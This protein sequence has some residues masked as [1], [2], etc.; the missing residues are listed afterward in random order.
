MRTTPEFAFQNKELLIAKLDKLNV[1]YPEQLI[2]YFISIYD[3]HKSNELRLY[4]K[5][6]RPVIGRNYSEIVKELISSKFDR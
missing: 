1:E 5:L 4:S 2:N 6:L 3:F